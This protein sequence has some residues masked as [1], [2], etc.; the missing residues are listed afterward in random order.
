MTWC[1]KTGRD[2]EDISDILQWPAVAKRLILSNRLYKDILG[3]LIMNKNTG[4]RWQF[5][6]NISHLEGN[7][8]IIG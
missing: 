6:W 2:Y 3:G 8:L 5:G 7:Y 4:P 1:I